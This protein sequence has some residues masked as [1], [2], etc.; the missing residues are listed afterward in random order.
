MERVTTNDGL[1]DLQAQ[2]PDSRVTID[3]VTIDP[4]GNADI[5]PNMP[6]LPWVVEALEAR[7]QRL[8]TGLGQ[9]ARLGSVLSV[10]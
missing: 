1:L 8:D 7:R 10:S 2:H 5:N 6:P 4:R 9:S 3:P